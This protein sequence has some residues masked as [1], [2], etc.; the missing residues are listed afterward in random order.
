[1]VNA[2]FKKSKNYK[3]KDAQQINKLENRLYQ[4]YKTYIETKADHPPT[5][6][7]LVEMYTNEVK[8]IES[9]VNILENIPT[10]NHT[11]DSEKLKNF[12]EK[13]KITLCLTKATLLEKKEIREEEKREQAS[14]KGNLD[15]EFSLRNL[16]DAI[17]YPGWEEELSELLKIYV[18]NIFNELI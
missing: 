14:K 2:A 9:M 1:M 10:F 16:Q 3:I 6:I 11:E 17:S 4:A 12:Y 13:E 15:K 5:N 18:L 8:N 7:S